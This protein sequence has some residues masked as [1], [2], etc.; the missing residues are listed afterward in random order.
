VSAESVAQRK[1]DGSG[2]LLARAGA[3]RTAQRVGPA[4]G[5]H[6]ARIQSQV[7]EDR[8]VVDMPGDLFCAALRGGVLDTDEACLAS[9]AEMR[10]RSSLTA[11]IARRA[12]FSHGA[13]AAESTTT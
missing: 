5:A 8:G 2:D 6:L 9:S 11:G 1:V 10:S 3:H 13:S 4:L 12:H 7:G